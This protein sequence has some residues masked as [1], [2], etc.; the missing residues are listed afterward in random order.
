ML[1]ILA[2]NLLQVTVG[3]IEEDRKYVFKTRLA[4]THDKEY[5]ILTHRLCATFDFVM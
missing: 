1:K 4:K 5:L 3:N 2:T